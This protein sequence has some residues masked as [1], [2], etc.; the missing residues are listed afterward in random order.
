MWNADGLLEKFQHVVEEKNVKIEC[1]E[2][3]ERDSFILLTSPFFQ[4]STGQS[5]ERPSWPTLLP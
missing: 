3:G 2:E 1:I 5:P 4:D